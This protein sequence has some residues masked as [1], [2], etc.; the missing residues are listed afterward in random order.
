VSNK[1]EEEAKRCVILAIK[2]PT[3]INLEEVLSLNAVKHLQ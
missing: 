3:I 1:V 2:V